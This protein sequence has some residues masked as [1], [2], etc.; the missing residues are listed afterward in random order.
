MD[1]GQS[2]LTG[3]S[4]TTHRDL[5]TFKPDLAAGIGGVDTGEDLHQRRLS[6]AILTTQAEDLS[7]FK[8]EVDV[9]QG[10]Y[11]WEGL[12]DVLQLKQLRHLHS[13]VSCSAEACDIAVKPSGC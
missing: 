9:L 1:D 6:C 11:S 10:L 7:C 13:F 4:H 8:V 3:M 5:L 2:Q 12:A